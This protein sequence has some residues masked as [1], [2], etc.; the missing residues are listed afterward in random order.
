[1]PIRVNGAL[2]DAHL[3]SS[4]DLI[5]VGD[6]GPV[7]RFRTY[8]DPKKRFKSIP[9]ALA[10]CMDCARAER[11]SL[12]GRVWAF[13]KRAP[14][15]ML[16]QTAPWTR[17]LLFSLVTLLLVVTLYL[18]YASLRF[19]RDLATQ[20]AVL[21]SVQEDRGS[22]TN[23]ELEGLRTALES[24]LSATLERVEALETMTEAAQRIVRN[25][26]PSIAFLVGKFGFTDA[27]GNVL[28]T[29]VDPDGRQLLN[30]F[31]N[32]AVGTDGN[33]PPVSI[34]F[35]GTGFV[36]D[37]TGLLLT[38]RHVVLPWEFDAG[39]RA[40]KTAGFKPVMNRF[41]GFLPGVTEAFRVSLAAASDSVDLAI[42]RCEESHE[43]AA[44]IDLSD[45]GASP[46]DEVYLMGYPTGVRALLARTD[47]RFVN[48]LLEETNRDLW[49]IVQ[50]LAEEK[51]IA[52]LATS[53]IVGQVTRNFVV[54]DAETTQGGS[55]GPVIGRD[56][57][58]VAINTAILNDFGGSN[59]GIP[60]EWAR[61]LLR[62]ARTTPQP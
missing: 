24:Q 22:L 30:R 32:P 54:Y 45:T 44:P 42:L 26:S 57:R 31:G 53:G 21:T 43:H 20:A 25:S 58:V 46:G 11:D 37:E 9:E 2:V 12:P 38:N 51:R 40:L 28:R 34:E 49:T 50:R 61:A 48:R 55:G 18:G 62:Q 56:G 29:V 52:P 47:V 36:V 16:Q 3:L 7:L 19:Q 27:D 15:E 39:S 41:V 1:A 5:V 35:T 60:V 33:G 23:A 17:S 13:M 10:D 6:H 4:G 8:V 14:H 59:L